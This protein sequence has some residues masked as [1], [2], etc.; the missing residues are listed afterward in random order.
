MPCNDAVEDESC[1]I[2]MNDKHEHG[3]EDPCSPFCHCHCCHTHVIKV[4]IIQPNLD[5]VEL[6]SRIPS[7]TAGFPKDITLTLLQPPQMYC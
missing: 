1:A 5:I 6:P 7:L 3:E 4:E 2:E